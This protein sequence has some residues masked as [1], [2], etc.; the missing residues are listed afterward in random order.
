MVIKKVSSRNP[1]VHLPSSPSGCT[2]LWGPRETLREVQRGLLR[3][4]G[5]S[6]VGY[7]F[8]EL[9]QN[10]SCSQLS[11]APLV[12]RVSLSD[13]AWHHTAP[14]PPLG[15]MPAYFLTLL[16]H[17]GIQLSELVPETGHLPPPSSPHTGRCQSKSFSKMPP[18]CVCCRWKCLY[19]AE[20]S[21]PDTL[22]STL[23]MLICF[24]LRTAI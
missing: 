17:C 12:P 13:P 3:S 1:G 22:P 21:I 20:G 4:Q 18:S 16:F 2:A 7:F 23:H 10:P 15:P 14:F 6:S 5:G 11:S 24:I 8:H 19:S 9:S